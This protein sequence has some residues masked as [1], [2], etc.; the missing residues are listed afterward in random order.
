MRYPASTDTQQDPIDFVRW[1]IYGPP[2]FFSG[3]Q[4]M[5]FNAILVIAFGVL[6][7][8]VAGASELKCRVVS[9]NESQ[10]VWEEGFGTY[11]DP[12]V[13]SDSQ[14]V[15]IESSGTTVNEVT[16]GQMR[17]QKSDGDKLSMT[18][19]NDKTNITI[20]P[21]D[22]AETIVITVYAS[23]RGVVLRADGTEGL[24]RVASIDCSSLKALETAYPG[25]RFVTQLSDRA[26]QALPKTIRTEMGKT[27]IP[28][29][30]G[31]GYYDLKSL[32]VYVVKDRAGETVGYL[33]AA[34]LSYTEGDDVDVLVRF[35]RNGLRHG[36]IEQL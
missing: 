30:L 24:G 8:H 26:F 6:A 12:S 28:F 4:D 1:P 17:W 31:D 21:K 23:Q 27:D 14:E 16:V 22:S 33:K 36:E 15:T 9:V 29:E 3:G 2:D 5:R 7:A 13:D 11:G 18:K 25:K 10:N 34:H 32:V 35:D 20:R 19:A